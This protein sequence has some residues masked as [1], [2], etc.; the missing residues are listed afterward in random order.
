MAICLTYSY[1][2]IY[3]S[4]RNIER[5]EI[6][7]VV[8]DCAWGV[9]GSKYRFKDYVVRNHGHHGHNPLI[10]ASCMWYPQVNIRETFQGHIHHHVSFLELQDLAWCGGIS[11]WITGTSKLAILCVKFVSWASVSSS[12][13]SQGDE[14]SSRKFLTGSRDIWDMEYLSCVNKNDQLSQLLPEIWINVDPYPTVPPI[15]KSFS[16]KTG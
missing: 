7:Q 5:S 8:L 11:N 9:S 12:H 15:Y 4:L 13:R 1:N 2:F 6:Y 16:T 10:F 14:F 3:K